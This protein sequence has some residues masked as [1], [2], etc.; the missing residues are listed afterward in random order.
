MRKPRDNAGK[1]GIE[2]HL[3]C[4]KSIDSKLGPLVALNLALESK[5]TGNT[6]SNC[7]GSQRD[8]SIS[9]QR[10]QMTIQPTSVPNLWFMG[11]R[12]N[13][14]TGSTFFLAVAKLE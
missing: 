7:V 8:I 13:P 1:P 12:L 4:N 3:Q 6:W 10:P 11:L 9:K 14:I 2:E 5:Q